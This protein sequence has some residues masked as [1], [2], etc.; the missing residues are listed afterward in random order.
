[1]DIAS[2]TCQSCL[3]WIGDFQEMKAFYVKVCYMYKN[4]L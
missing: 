1:M 3:S 2:C 4:G